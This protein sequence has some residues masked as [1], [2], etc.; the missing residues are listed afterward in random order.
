MFHILDPYEWAGK[1]VVEVGCGQGPTLN[2]LARLGA[3]VY[4]L[5]MSVESLQRARAG[6]VEL[7]SS[8]YA[9][10]IQA[11]AEQL[12]FPDGYFDIAISLGVLHHTPDTAAGVREI[13]RM[14]K[15]G[16]VAVVM[17]YRFGTPKW[18]MTRTLRGMSQCADLVTGK[19]YTL[20]ERP[21]ARQQEG[22]TA[23]TALM[24][25]F[26]VP[27]L[28]AFSNRQAQH[29]FDDFGEV[30][31]SNCLPG[32]RRLVDVLPV[33]RLLE[34]GLDWIDRRTERIWGFYQVVEAKK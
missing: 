6:A 32:F 3:T 18:W 16:G 7:A 20:L 10:L 5:D 21:R 22:N 15:P 2:H 19:P 26:G 1:K 8:E 29:L 30:H 27:I 17:L 25:L 23:G 31:I 14:L 13:H 11:D 12:P 4:G 28:K 24:E 34:S 9:R 33:L